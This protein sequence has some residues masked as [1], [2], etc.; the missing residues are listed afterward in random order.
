[1]T[2]NN[3]TCSDLAFMRVSTP[4]LKI[5]MNHYKQQLPQRDYLQLVNDVRKQFERYMEVLGGFHPGAERAKAAHRLLNPAIEQSTVT[6][7]CK[8]GCGACCH[9]EVEITTDEAELLAEEVRAG[10]A[11]DMTQLNNQASRER[12]AASWLRGVHPE[13]RCVFLGQDQACQVYESRPS[14]CR[15]HVVASDP[16]DCMVLDRQ[17]Q[18]ILIPLAEIALS[19]ALSQ[20]GNSYSS[21]SKGVLSALSPGSDLVQK[22]DSWSEGYDWQQE[23]SEAPGADSRSDDAPFKF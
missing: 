21:L 16:Q 9:L 15:K 17:P 7:T 12:K 11:L 5:M 8:K 18:P 1:M 4:Q 22:G 19:A 10:F 20:P 14:I 23:V 3:L 13:N 2:S 6:P